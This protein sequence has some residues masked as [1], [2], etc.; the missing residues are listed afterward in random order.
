M[1]RPSPIRVRFALVAIF[2][3]LA[4]GFLLPSGHAQFGRPPGPPPVR[5][6]GAG[7][8]GRPGGITGV[9]GGIT[10]MPGPPLRPPGGI[11]GMPGGI[12]GRPGGITGMPGG[13]ITGTPG[14][15]TGMPGRL[16]GGLGGGIGGGRGEVVWTCTG[17]N[18]ELGRGPVDPGQS[19]CPH[20]GARLTGPSGP[21]AFGS[22]PGMH[23]GTG[24]RPYGGSVSPP[25]AAPPSGP[26]PDTAPPA[27]PETSAPGAPAIG[28]LPFLGS[29]SPDDSS[30]ADTSSSSES[31]GG[32]GKSRKV[33]LIVGL[34]IATVFLVGV[35]VML[36]MVMRNTSGSR[37]VRA[38]RRPAFDFDDD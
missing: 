30:P 22:N 38:R 5:P 35:V 3:L 25:P 15:I 7:M 24:T 34:T 1:T 17:C 27:V 11:T 37:P 18:G 32:S 12:P 31:P 6:P 19:I 28:A 36:V 9:P 4:L 33:L 8:P 10:G 29:S 14:G 2:T 13:G 26:P 16:G 21:A 23:S 20:C